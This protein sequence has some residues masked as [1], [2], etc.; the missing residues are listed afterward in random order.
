MPALTKRSQSFVIIGGTSGVGKAIGQRLIST[1]PGCHVLVTGLVNKCPSGIRVHNWR[2][3]NTG[4]ACQN[5]LGLRQQP[6]RRCV[7]QRGTVGVGLCGT[8]TA[9]RRYNRHQRPEYCSAPF[10]A[11]TSVH[12]QNFV[13]VYEQ[14]SWLHP[15][16]IHPELLRRH[17]GI[18]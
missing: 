4:C 6:T 14:L 16:S 13:R 7:L 8:H 18:H 17:E 1:H 2:Y 12:P 10:A 5:C 3:T 11:A 15:G 9:K